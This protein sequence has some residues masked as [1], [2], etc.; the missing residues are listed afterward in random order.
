MAR[1]KSSALK[2]LADVRQ[3]RMALE[4]RAAELKRAAA[5]ELGLVVLDAGGEDLGP[6]ALR[7]LVAR[8]AAIGTDAPLRQLAQADRRTADATGLEPGTS[9]A[10][11]VGNG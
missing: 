1:K 11:E 7:G 10:G 4:S 3:E 6:E 2:A 9:P 5:L 8:A